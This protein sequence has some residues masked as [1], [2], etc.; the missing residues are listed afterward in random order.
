IAYRSGALNDPTI[1]FAAADGTGVTRTIA[2]PQRSCEPSDWSPDGSYLMVTVH[3]DDIWTIPVTPGAVAQPLLAEPFVERDGRISPDGRW[4]AYVSNESGRPEVSVRSLVGP[5]R[6]F[7]VSKG[8]GDQPVWRRQPGEL[9]YAGGE[10]RIYSVP[11]HQDE[12]NELTFGAATMLDVPPLGERHWGTIY[13]VAPDGRR[14]YFPHQTADRG[15]REF[16]VVLN[17]K[18]LVK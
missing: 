6:R 8:G 4:F 7:V 18:A 17:W 2:C 13:D 3:G 11:V 15:P 9:F 14:V 10:G 16:G 12:P 1:S 5:P